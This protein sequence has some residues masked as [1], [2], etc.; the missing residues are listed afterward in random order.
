MQQNTTTVN[1]TPQDTTP[2][3]LTTVEIDQGQTVT[4]EDDFIYK[5]YQK[6]KTLPL[7]LRIH[8]AIGISISVLC[9]FIWRWISPNIDTA[10]WWFIFPMFLFAMT[11][12]FHKYVIVDGATYPESKAKGAFVIIGLANLLLFFSNFVMGTEKNP[13]PWFIYPLFGSIMGTLYL[14]HRQYPTDYST[15]K[16]ITHEY[17]IFNLLLF[18]TWLLTRGFPWFFYPF[19]ILAYPLLTLYVKKVY[20]ENRHTIFALILGVDVCIISFIT[21]VFTKF[22]F[23][24]FLVVWGLFGVGMFFLWRT[25]RSGYFGMDKPQT[26]Q[27]TTNQ[28]NSSNLYPNI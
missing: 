14:Y 24:W 25:T 5:P 11:L 15:L 10:P 28:E 9:L 1:F 6:V 12:A 19:L 13:Y 18:I 20:K 21:W 4:F 26:Q 3:N 2:T 22:W 23:P 27:N 8:M 16:L 7:F 17:L